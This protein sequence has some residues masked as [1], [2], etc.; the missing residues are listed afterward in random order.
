MKTS[1]PQTTTKELVFCH[2]A[3]FIEAARVQV[4][5]RYFESTAA[6]D[7]FSMRAL[8]FHVTPVED[9]G[10]EP[11]D[12]KEVSLVRLE[13]LSRPLILFGELMAPGN[14]QWSFR[15]IQLSGSETLEQLQVQ[16]GDCLDAV[17]APRE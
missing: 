15:D 9:E 17:P 13:P 5:L 6:K 1:Q 16:H 3:H 2:C 10:A 7:S 12:F 11:H 8:S 14:L 4:R